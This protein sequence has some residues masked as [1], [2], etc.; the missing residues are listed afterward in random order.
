SD[1][2]TTG[3]VCGGL[4]GQ[5]AAFTVG[6]ELASKAAADA[7]RGARI[8]AQK[9]RSSG[10]DERRAP[11]RAARA[12]RV[13]DLVKAV[14]HHPRVAARRLRQSLSRRGRNQALMVV[15][16]NRT[17]LAALPAHTFVIGKN[18]LAA[19]HQVEVEG[20]HPA[21][22]RINMERSEEHTSELQSR[23]D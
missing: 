1:P 6:R 18:F 13:A 15:D 9:S 16:R 23:F 10:L 20:E 11:V 22:D 21:G 8:A 3:S 4:T 12:G 17:N 2:G 19:A 14:V 7:A 5:L